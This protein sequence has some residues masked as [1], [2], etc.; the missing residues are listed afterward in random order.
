MMFGNIFMCS[1]AIQY[2]IIH[3]A[4]V[5]IL[6]QLIKLYFHCSVVEFLYIVLIQVLYRYRFCYYFLHVSWPAEIFYFEEVYR[7]LGVFFKTVAV[8]CILSRKPLPILYLFILKSFILLASTFR[9]MI[10]LDLSFGYH[11]R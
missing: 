3:Q 9:S 10:H 5:L 8:F 6:L 2:S 4:S 7:V 11:V 1:L